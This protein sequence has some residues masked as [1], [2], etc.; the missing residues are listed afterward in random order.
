MQL[1]LRLLNHLMSNG[2]RM[3]IVDM[4]FNIV[5]LNFLESQWKNQYVDDQSTAIPKK[6]PK[7]SYITTKYLFYRLLL[8]PF[9]INT[10]MF[11]VYDRPLVLYG[12]DN[13]I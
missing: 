11:S 5:F 4:G 10:I 6:N 8:N 7:K 12:I 9:N 3:F 1:L 2:Y 13:H